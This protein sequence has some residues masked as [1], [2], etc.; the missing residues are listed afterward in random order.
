MIKKIIPL[1]LGGLAIGTTEFVIMGLLPDIAHTLNIS[2][3]KAGHFIS[4]YALGVVIGAPL[5]VALSSKFPPKKI[6]MALMAIFIIFNGISALM[7]DYYSF[8]GARFFSGLPHGAFFGVG[9][10]V[11]KNLAPPE[12]QGIAISGMFSGLTVANLAMVPL[13]TFIGHE[14]SWRI[15][16]GVVSFLGFVTMV[17]IFYWLPVMKPLSKGNILEDM[18]F[19]KTPVALFLLLIVA[20]G[21]GGLFSWFSYITPLMTQ[22]SHFEPSKIPSIMILAGFGMLIGNF[23]GGWMADKMRPALA[24]TILFAFFIVLLVLVFLYSGDQKTS[25]ILTFFC[26]MLSMSVGSPINIIMIRAAKKS[27]MLGAAFMQ[28][29]FNVAN[30]IGA[31]TGGIPLERGYGYEYP[32]L[33]GAIMAFFGMLLCIVFMYRFKPFTQ[34]ISNDQSYT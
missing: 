29:A 21:F 9:S 27:E 2:I 30:S 22:V 14:F 7:P 19:F 4:A 10:V 31:Y 8:L 16:F 24:S 28:A 23:L 13:V 12:K 11:A 18:K 33:V 15:A 5:L 20:V 17:S 6:L 26:G 32:A 1:T 3:P 34:K 25:L